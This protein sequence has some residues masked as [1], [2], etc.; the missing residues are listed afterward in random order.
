MREKN[1][2]FIVRLSDWDL[3]VELYYKRGR[4]HSFQADRG[5][6]LGQVPDAYDKPGAI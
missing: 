3:E 6:C 5:F 1:R 4:W 2:G